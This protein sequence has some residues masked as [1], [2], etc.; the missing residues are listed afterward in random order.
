QSFG[1][2]CGCVGI[3]NS[4]SSLIKVEFICN[5]M[6]TSFDLHIGICFYWWTTHFVI[7]RRRPIAKTNKPV[8]IIGNFSNLSIGGLQSRCLWILRSHV[9]DIYFMGLYSG[10]LFG[11]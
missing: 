10:D 6:E 11:L 9:G 2:S 4:I 7:C 8:S 5:T 1:I 3:R